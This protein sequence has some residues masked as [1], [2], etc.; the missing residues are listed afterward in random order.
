MAVPVL[1]F[2]AENDEFI[3]PRVQ[4]LWF[5][6]FRA[7]GGRGELV[8]A[9]PFPEQRGHAVFTSPAGVPIWT[10]AVAAF[11]K[12]QGLGLPF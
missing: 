12:S 10:A 3:G 1:W 9:P 5:E 7:A 11:F 4:K 8:V 6:S 2:Y